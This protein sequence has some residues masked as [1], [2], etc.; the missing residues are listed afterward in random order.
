MGHCWVSA[1]HL[2]SQWDQRP[3]RLGAEAT[4]GWSLRSQ[5]CLPCGDPPAPSP[6]PLAVTVARPSQ[7]G[8][9]WGHGGL[10][11]LGLGLR[12]SVDAGGVQECAE[13][14]SGRD[15]ELAGPDF[16]L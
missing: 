1:R 11:A 5:G 7:R 15:E 4:L 3:A 16:P 12:G 13:R 10:W 14:K 2:G 8:L 6:G 9:Q